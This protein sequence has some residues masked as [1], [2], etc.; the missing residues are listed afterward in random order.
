[1]KLFI[2]LMKLLQ[3]WQIKPLRVYHLVKLCLSLERLALI[4]TKQGVPFIYDEHTA[5]TAVYYAV[6]LGKSYRLIDESMLVDLKLT[7]QQIREMSLF[8]VRKLSNSYTT[9]EVKGNI[10]TLL[11]QMTGM[12]QVGY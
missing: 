7:E 9:D 3:K 8:N 12:M 11:T 6:D 5:E 4:K 10:F 1:M 2:T